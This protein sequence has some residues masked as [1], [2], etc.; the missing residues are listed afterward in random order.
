MIEK[1]QNVRLLD[2]LALGPALIAIAG[3]GKM[4]EL[5]RT[6]LFVSGILTIAY[7]GANWIANNEAQK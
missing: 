4:S 6:F 5:A 7:N 3:R 2:V 1:S